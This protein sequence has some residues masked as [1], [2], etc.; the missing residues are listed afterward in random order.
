[1]SAVEKLA[2]PRAT[3]DKERA[4]AFGGVELVARNGEQIELQ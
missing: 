3:F 2:E 4:D 1:M